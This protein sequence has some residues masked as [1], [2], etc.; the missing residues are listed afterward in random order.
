MFKRF[1]GL[2]LIYI[3]LLGLIPSGVNVFAEIISGECGNGV[4]WIMDEYGVLD[5][6]GDG[7]IYD[8]DSPEETPFYEY[9]DKVTK[10]IIEDDVTR[11]GKYA[12][13]GLWRARQIYIGRGVKGLGAA[14]FGNVCNAETI[15]YN[16][17]VCSFDGDSL[18]VMNNYLPQGHNLVI[19]E[20]VKYIGANTF[21]KVNIFGGTVSTVL[22]YG[23]QEDWNKIYIH[24]DGNG[25]LNKV[26]FENE[27]IRATVSFIDGG[28]IVGADVDFYVILGFC[29]LVLAI[30]NEN[31]VLV[32][33]KIV[34]IDPVDKGMR[35]KCDVESDYSGY[36]AKVFFVNNFNDMIPC[37]KGYQKTFLTAR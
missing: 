2:G 15:Y 11:I 7:K 36:T 20:D 33:M 17:E 1:L 37:C 21:Y 9:K 12:F 13:A 27:K 25:I 28:G 3:M 8:Y 4:F 35:I 23:T 31:D 29:K 34:D 19:G 26:L 24:P 10:I 32:D 22:F 6:F 18:D 30:Y 16:A 5:V 14:T